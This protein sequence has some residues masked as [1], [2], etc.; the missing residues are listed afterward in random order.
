MRRLLLL[1]AAFLASAPAA[2]A[3]LFPIEPQPVAAGIWRGHAP[4]L[5]GHYRQ[6]QEMGFQAVLDIRGNQ[7]RASARERRRLERM[8]IIYMNVPMG[9][10]PLGDG[11]GEQVLAALQNPPA[12]PLY[13]HCNIDRDRASAV[14]GVYRVRVQGWSRAA[15]IEEAKGFGL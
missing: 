7:P 8:G 1:T 14:I 12:L 6:L 2:P 4:W 15:A 10:R 5:R 13:V 11:S 3:Q 9:F